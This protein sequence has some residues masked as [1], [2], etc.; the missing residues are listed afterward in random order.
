MK[1]GSQELDAVTDTQCPV[2]ANIQPRGTGCGDM[3]GLRGNDPPVIA[4]GPV[5]DVLGVER[6]VGVL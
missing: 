2:V 1:D 4:Q 6:T 3:G 5:D